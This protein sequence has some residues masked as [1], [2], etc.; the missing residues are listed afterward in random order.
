M[1]YTQYTG[2]S[3]FAFTLVELLVV[4]AIIG[5]L[6]S[7][8]LPAVQAAREAARRMSCS[9][10]LRQ[11]GLAMHNYHDTLGTFPPGKVSQPRDN[12]TNSGN[13]FGWGALLLPY[14]EQSN[15]QSLIDFKQKVYAPENLAAG[16]TL[17]SM[18]LCPSDQ[19]RLS[20][21][22]TYYNPDNGWALETL[23]MAPSHYGGIITEKISDYG[24]ATATDGWTLQ[25]DEL[26]VIL[27]SRSVSMTEITDG[28]SNTM[29]VTEACSYEKGNPKTY[30][31][32]SWAMGTNIFRKTPAAINYKPK[33]EHFDSGTLN[34]SC[35]SCS[36]YQ[37][38]T[39]SYHTGGAYSLICDGSCRF[40]SE[41]T[42][43][44]IV[45][46]L[47]TKDQGEVTTVP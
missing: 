20:R 33:C 10:N 29:M 19:D 41:M 27:E 1:K 28:T 32:G 42:D 16:Q 13:Y 11:I 14:C 45:A 44:N 40:L 17:L 23:R 2:R 22:I 47:I 6:I 4:I 46:A 3:W 26:G 43:K 37:Y 12:G 18:Y 36:L 25:H 24:R 34:W 38:E 7:L 8:L 30:D 21:N 15:V 31:N 5:I 39:R 9:N 35:S